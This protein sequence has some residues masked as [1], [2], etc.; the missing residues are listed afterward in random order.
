MR[1]KDDFA[2]VLRDKC[3]PVALAAYQ[4]TWDG[5]LFHVI[6]TDRIANGDLARKPIYAPIDVIKPHFQH[7]FRPIVV[8]RTLSQVG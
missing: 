7:Y 1:R 5:T 8:D 2:V 6:M 4:T 3:S